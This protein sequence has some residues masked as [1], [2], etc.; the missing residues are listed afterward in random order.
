MPNILEACDAILANP[1]DYD[2]K[3]ET[4]GKNASRASR[5]VFQVYKDFSVIAY[6]YKKA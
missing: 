6:G 4:W 5:A 2:Y 1:E 3:T